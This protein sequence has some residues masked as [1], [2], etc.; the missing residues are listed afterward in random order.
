VS[1][2]ADKPND[3]FRILAIDGGG[4][5][6]LISALVLKEIE[7]RLNRGRDGK[8]RIRVADCFHLVAG[9]SA[10]GLA[11]LA[12]TAPSDLDADDLVAFYLEDG[13]RIFHRSLGRKLLTLWGMLG[14]KYSSAPVRE[15]I[16]KRVGPHRIS[17]AT[18]DLL[19]TS[20]DM[21]ASDPYFFKRWRALEN[22]ERDVP[23]ADA[24]L[25][26][27]AAPTYFGSHG[28]GER[29][30]VDGGVFANDPAVAAIA[31]A[32]GRASDE[33]AE[34]EPADLFLVSIGTG[35]FNVGF[36]QRETSGWGALR[37]IHGR[38]GVPI[39]NTIMGGVSDGTDY[40]AHMLLNHVRGEKV[41]SREEI[42]H[43]PRYYRLQ[44]ELD[45][46][47]A[48]DDTSE[49][50]LTKVLPDAAKHLIDER[51]DEIDEIVGRLLGGRS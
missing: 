4:I 45:G 1:P 7:E 5:R 6:G 9:T 12:L 25:S 37:W 46:P 33:P 15:A 10:G 49:E 41:P 30:L 34:L 47:I 22:A 21:H 36:E 3:R 44:A 32:L 14:P 19:V 16:E 40:W 43:G 50:V 24:A 27:S 38:G 2:T 28:V 51:S 8:E 18:R 13:R 31:E 23:V 26:T 39:L 42:G 11:A 35:E 17:E 20:Y 48:L 29:A